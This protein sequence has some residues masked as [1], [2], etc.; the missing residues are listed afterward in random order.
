MENEDYDSENSKENFAKPLRV[1]NRNNYGLS[2]VKKNNNDDNNKGGFKKRLKNITSRNKANVGNTSNNSSS[3]EKKEGLKSKENKLLNKEHGLEE[4]KANIR[5]LFRKR[6]KNALVENLSEDAQKKAFSNVVKKIIITHP[7][8]VVILFLIIAILIVFVS[9]ALT[10]TGG[11]VAYKD[12]GC[13]C[14]MIKPVDG[15][16]IN[17]Y[18]WK[19]VSEQ[20]LAH[21]GI[22]ISAP[23][24][25]EVY[26][27]KKG[28]VKEISFSKKYGNYIII[29]HD[30]KDSKTYKTL[31]ANLSS[32]VEGLSVGDTV[33]KK[34]VI[35]YVGDSSEEDG[36]HLHFEIIENGNNVSP[37]R[38]YEY[39]NPVGSC[40]PN[41]T[42]LSVNK[43]K[44]LEC[45]TLVKEDTNYKKYC[46]SSGSMCN[47]TM[48]LPLDTGCYN[49][50]DTGGFKDGLP[51]CWCAQGLFRFYKNIL[52]SEGEYER[53]AKFNAIA[54]DAYQYWVNNENYNYFESSISPEDYRPGAI[55]VHKGSGTMCGNI[56][57][58]H[59][60]TV[61]EA[62]DDEVTIYECNGNGDGMCYYKKLT[63]DEVVI[64]T[65]ENGGF[66][67][68]VYILDCDEVEEKESNDNIDV[69]S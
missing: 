64:K 18:G 19:I 55:A 41:I 51:G 14:D 39:E 4:K 5:K 54:G 27:V 68:W 63:P 12:P 31:Y 13:L 11:F 30:P 9:F 67:G 61:V 45:E 28:V 37:N 50:K 44:E 29:E 40:D 49:Y 32:S 16:L 42:G 48:N 34:K 24:E 35:G 38:L 21:K 20:P 69:S 43:I 25:T 33:S 22:D 58:G 52:S 62:L 2:S 17:G 1:K 10:S 8:V 53:F 26:A 60:W 36:T 59:V 23:S 56:P 66:Y 46:R 47:G 65:Q 57:C 6:K 3:L 7:E 15:E